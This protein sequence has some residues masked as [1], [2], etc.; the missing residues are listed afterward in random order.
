MADYYGSSNGGS[1]WSDAQ[2]IAPVPESNPEDKNDDGVSRQNY[3]Q[4]GYMPMPMI[5]PLIVVPYSGQMQPLDRYSPDGSML[6]NPEDGTYEYYDEESAPARK[7]CVTAIIGLLLG[8]ISVAL[9]AV[10]YFV[11]DLAFTQWA[12][13]YS[14]IAI[15]IDFFDNDIAAMEITELLAYVG[16]IVY[17]VFTVLTLIINLVSVKAQ[18]YPIIGKIF[19]MLALIG[20]VLSLVIMFIDKNIEAKLGIG[21]YIVTVLAV[22]TGLLA[23]AGRRK[24]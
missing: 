19:G 23:L 24:I 13:G 5:Q 15:V 10:G 21:A 14:V 1:F 2:S 6:Y 16:L 18:R 9:L 17:A 8:I 3:A 11:K 12:E 22:M 7:V 4:G 20:A